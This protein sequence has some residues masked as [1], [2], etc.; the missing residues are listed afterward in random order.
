MTI[1]GDD[2]YKLTS[3]Y[4]TRTKKG[5]TE[6]VPFVE[7]ENNGERITLLSGTGTLDTAKYIITT[8]LNLKDLNKEA[9]TLDGKETT[10]IHYFE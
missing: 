7:V 9:Y 6:Y 1:D 8:D 10:Q 5:V 4:K 3:E 2:Q